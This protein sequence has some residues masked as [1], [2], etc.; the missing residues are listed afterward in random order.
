MRTFQGRKT[1]CI[2]FEPD[3]RLMRWQ[4]FATIIPTH[5]SLGLHQVFYRLPIIKFT[6]TSIPPK[7]IF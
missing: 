4:K 7:D 3:A 2:D 5:Y 6:H 1:A